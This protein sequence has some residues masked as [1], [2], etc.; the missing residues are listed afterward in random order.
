MQL[1]LPLNSFLFYLLLFSS[2]VLYYTHAYYVE[3]KRAPIHINERTAW[4]LSNQNWVEKSQLLLTGLV[5]LLLLLMLNGLQPHFS[6]I[7]PFSWIILI[8]FISF[9]LGYYKNLYPKWGNWGLR[10]NGLIKPLIIGLVWAGMVSFSPV[11]FY[12]LSFPGTNQSL[13]RLTWLLLIKNWIFISILSMLFDFK[14]Y[15]NDANQQLKTWVVKFGIRKTLFWIILPLSISSMTAYWLFALEQS[16]NLHRI[17]FNSIPYA[18]LITVCLL[19]Y[20][21]K[22]IL[23]YL[24]IIDGLML[25]KAICGIIGMY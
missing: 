16:F 12:D 9:G 23:Y 18:L 11:L 2:S 25:A 15:A 3:A 6:K 4:Y 14:D 22:S 13:E 20:Q 19:M 8:I 5:F 10:G 7:N 24:A 1:N 21:R 17:I